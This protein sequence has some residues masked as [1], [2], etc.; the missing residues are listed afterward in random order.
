M[1]L[2]SSRSTIELP[3]PFISAG[4]CSQG[5][6][7]GHD[8]PA[9]IAESFSPIGPA[10]I[11][12]PIR[13]C[14]PRHGVSRHRTTASGIR[15]FPPITQGCRLVTLIVEIFAGHPRGSL[16]ERTQGT[17]SFP[18]NEFTGI[19]SAIARIASQWR[20]RRWRHRQRWRHAEVTAPGRPGRGHAA[21]AAPFAV[22]SRGNIF[23]FSLPMIR[24][25]PP[26]CY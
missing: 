14:R 26:P 20:G 22:I 17:L 16:F 3:I 12:G 11:L 10:P 2:G 25:A 5:S 24:T 1:R 8:P 13:R 23:T 4:Q 6:A 15:N 21:R 9:S 18:R 7:V 19:I